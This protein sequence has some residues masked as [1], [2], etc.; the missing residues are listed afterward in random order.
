VT[1]LEET[2]ADPAAGE[3]RQRIRSR[4]R[5]RAAERTTAEQQ[6]AE[7][8]TQTATADDPALLDAGPRAVGRFTTAPPEVREA[9]YTALDKG[10]CLTSGRDGRLR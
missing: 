6:L 1:E 3:Y 7:L 9:L 10:A 4:F 8:E 5:D 2:G